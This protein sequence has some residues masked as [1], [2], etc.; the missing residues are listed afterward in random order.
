MQTDR[1]NSIILEFLKKYYI[2]NRIKKNLNDL[3]R[4]KKPFESPIVKV[5]CIIDMDI[6]KDVEPLLQ[7]I[8]YYNV[9]PE[10]YIFLGYKKKSEETH[11]D[12]VPFL[13][14]NE[15]NW[16]GK[17]RNYHAD[18]LSEQEYDVLIN[19]FNEPKL[20]LLLLS[21]S[22]KAKL[23]IGF[24]GIDTQFNDIIIGCKLEEEAI[25]T[26]EVKKI[27]KTILT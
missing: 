12:G 4:Y 17:I 27:L 25:F 14:N 18:R 5:G 1:K 20:P 24:Q 10:N 15:I 3:K 9:R 19:Y 23:R 26:N 8:K 16:Q 21:S 6:I 7:L 11:A 22:I 13:V 2:K